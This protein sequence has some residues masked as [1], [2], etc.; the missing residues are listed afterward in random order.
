[1]STKTSEVI[2]IFAAKGAD[3][4]HGAIASGLRDRIGSRHVI[5]GPKQTSVRLLA[6]EGGTAY[7]GLYPRKGAVLLNIRL[8]SPPKSSCNSSTNSRSTSVNSHLPTR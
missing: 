7:A 1:M 2:G 4:V 8:Q 3:K 5:E 6:S